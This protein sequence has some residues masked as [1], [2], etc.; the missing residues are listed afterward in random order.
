MLD[1]FFETCSEAN[2]KISQKEKVKLGIWETPMSGTTCRRE[3]SDYFL[4]SGCYYMFLAD[5]MSE[6]K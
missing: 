4:L 2:I 3:C 5:K 1:V 6:L